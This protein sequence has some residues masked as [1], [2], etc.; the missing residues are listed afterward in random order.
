MSNPGHVTRGEESTYFELATG[1]V[2]V[3]ATITT[4]TT[5][6]RNRVR[7]CLVNNSTNVD[8]F[9]S[10]SSSLTAGNGLLLP[11]R[12]PLWLPVYGGLYGITSSGTAAVS[13]GSVE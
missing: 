11:P 10:T 13:Y 4:I 8:V 3:T 6:E 2:S 12:V 1:Q 5:V 9:V 7:I